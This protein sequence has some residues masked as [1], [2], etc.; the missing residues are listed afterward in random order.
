MDKDL[1]F[2]LNRF[3]GLEDN[4]F[5]TVFSESKLPECILRIIV[6]FVPLKTVL[7]SKTIKVCSNESSVEDVV[8]ITFRDNWLTEHD[9][10]TLDQ[11]HLLFETNLLT[12]RYGVLRNNQDDFE[13]SGWWVYEN[14]KINFLSKVDLFPLKRNKQTKYTYTLHMADYY[15]F[16]VLSNNT[17]I[18]D[19]RK[20]ASEHFEEF[21]KLI[22]DQMFE[23]QD[24]LPSWI[25]ELLH[26]YNSYDSP[27]CDDTLCAVSDNVN[28]S[29]SCSQELIDK[30]NY[31]NI[32][33]ELKDSRV[34]KFQRR[35]KFSRLK[36]RRLKKIKTGNNKMRPTKK[37]FIKR[38][39]RV[40]KKNVQNQ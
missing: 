35:R 40:H 22:V 19:V 21:E 3:K 23:N 25:K 27:M 14:E 38:K 30:T 8:P 39:S 11:F 32:T 2:Y 15:F 12:R 4:I 24:N 10:V 34:G 18:P 6:G 31:S 29:G 33:D 37:H 16:Q 26:I 5:D 17:K 7:C 28:L 20:A 13:V 1:G 36:K 9:C